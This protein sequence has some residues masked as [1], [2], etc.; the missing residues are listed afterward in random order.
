MASA[1]TSLILLS[2]A[3]LASESGRGSSTPSIICCPYSGDN[4]TRPKL[5]QAIQVLVV[6]TACS[7]SVL[8]RLV[9]RPSPRFHP[10]GGFAIRRTLSGRGTRRKHS[11]SETHLTSPVKLTSLSE[12]RLQ[13]PWPDILF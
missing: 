3:W 13:G 8:P 6:A 2:A 12:V 11:G 5:P 9:N 1:G 7:N 10:C 4:T